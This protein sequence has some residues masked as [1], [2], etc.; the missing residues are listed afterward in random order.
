MAFLM[1]KG[2]CM[3]QQDMKWFNRS[4]YLWILK[5]GSL[6]FIFSVV[7]SSAAAAEAYI[8]EDEAR[9]LVF[10]EADTFTE[11]VLILSEEQR[12]S[13]SRVVEKAVSRKIFNCRIARSGERLLGYTVT[14]TVKSRSEKIRYVLA[15][16]PAL[17]VIS[18]EIIEYQS[19]RGAK[20]RQPRFLNQFSGRTTDDFDKSRIRHVSGATLSSNAM[21]RSIRSVLAYLTV[22]FPEE[23]TAGNFRK[24]FPVTS[25]SP[26]NVQEEAMEKKQAFY[27]RSR[28]IM[29]APLEI[30]FFAGNRQN[31]FAA[32]EEAFR[33]ADRLDRMLSVYHEDSDVS[34]VNRMAGNKVSVSPKVVELMQSAV[35]FGRKTGGGFDV[36]VGPLI[37]LWREASE[38]NRVPS[39]D[40]IEKT[41]ALIGP[42]IITI[43]EA[44][45]Q[46]CLAKKGAYINLGGIGKGY[47]IDRVSEILERRGLYS[48]L[49]NFGGNIRALGP[50]PGEKGWEVVIVDPGDPD[51]LIDKIILESGAVSTSADYERGF[52]IGGETFS[53]IINPSTGHPARG[54]LN[55]TVF[56]DKA[57]EADA[58]STGLYSLGMEEARSLAREN[59]VSVMII[60]ENGESFR[61]DSY[62]SLFAE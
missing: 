52:K 11:E 28:Y 43:D 15:V 54:N 34:R 10:P 6:L 22:L 5:R 41:L 33:E 37:R 21:A 50:P 56:A 24:D 36:T 38:Q 23:R 7:L 8:S 32:F 45:S 12:A 53:H 35:T 2:N 61:S 57:R 16:S 51:F 4:D 42:G 3:F 62:L 20:V 44:S 48:A 60:A 27:R 49:I 58:L 40:Q 31:A 47:A 39:T 55:I 46:V 14:D 1:N 19:S 13:I 18:V 29:G 26:E 17:E 25:S 59:Q 9:I 30:L